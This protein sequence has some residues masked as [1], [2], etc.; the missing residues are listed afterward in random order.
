MTMQTQVKQWGQYFHTLEGSAM[1][2][3]ELY[4]G[5]HAQEKAIVHLYAGVCTFHQSH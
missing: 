5:Q 2:E 3:G 1:T 4:R